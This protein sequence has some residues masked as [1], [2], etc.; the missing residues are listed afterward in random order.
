MPQAASSDHSDIPDPLSFRRVLTLSPCVSPAIFATAQAAFFCG[1]HMGL[2]TS[3]VTGLMAF[4]DS[5]THGHPLS[6]DNKVARL[7]HSPQVGKRCGSFG[8]YDINCH[9]CLQ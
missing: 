4:A 2:P 3:L 7:L 1:I 6:W 5:P 9:F 8:A